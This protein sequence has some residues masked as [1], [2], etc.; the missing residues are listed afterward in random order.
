M[1]VRAWREMATWLRDNIVCGNTANICL[2]HCSV[3]GLGLTFNVHGDYPSPALISRV[4]T[5]I[6]ARRPKPPTCCVTS[7]LQREATPKA[8]QAEAEKQSAVPTNLSSV[9]ATNDQCLRCCVSTKHAPFLAFSACIKSAPLRFL[10]PSILC[11]E[12]ALGGFC[13][14]FDM[15]APDTGREIART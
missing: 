8:C 2:L 9:C 1:L 7:Q 6:F 12:L 11:N 3:L 5:N 14:R 4:Q 13:G 15:P 10:A